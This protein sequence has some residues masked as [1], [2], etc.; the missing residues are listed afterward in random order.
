MTMRLFQSEADFHNVADETLEDIL[1]AVE[2][3]FEDREEV[4]VSCASGVLTIVFPP[5]GTWVINKQTPNKQIWWSSPLSGPRRY[6]YSDQRGKWVYTR[7]VE[8][9]DH[10][11][12][13]GE[14]LSTEVKELYQ[15]DLELDV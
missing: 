4:E 14:A 12:S 13:L 7:S 15:L 1:D 2:E 3:L 8:D 9:E 11:E 10:V 6:E 5:H